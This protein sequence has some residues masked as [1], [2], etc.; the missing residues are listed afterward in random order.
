M[1]IPENQL[2]EYVEYSIVP[3]DINS[4]THKTFIVNVKYKKTGLYALCSVKWTFYDAVTFSQ[5]FTPV[6]RDKFDTSK[7]KVVR[8][9]R[10]AILVDKELGALRIA[11]EGLKPSIELGE[12]SKTIVTLSNEGL[13]E[14]DECYI[15]SCEPLFT[16]FGLKPIGA[17]K[18]NSALDVEIF[19]RGSYLKKNCLIPL[20]FLYKSKDTWNYIMGYFEITIEE[21]FHLKYCI[22]DLQN[23]RRFISLDISNNS[24]RSTLVED[25]ELQ[26]VRLNSNYWEIM[27]DSHKL[28]STKDSLIVCF[29]IQKREDWDP[30]TLYLNRKHREVIIVFTIL[31]V[32]AS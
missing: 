26:L 4:E 6:F 28:I 1:I 15:I 12:I 18:T 17:I 27:R 3:S 8:L 10:D 11:S 14:I 23:E 32:Q 2:Q 25:L 22:E 20:F 30:L 21:S 31:G 24:K 29:E 16:G 5:S 13:S 7:G 9:Y 19:V